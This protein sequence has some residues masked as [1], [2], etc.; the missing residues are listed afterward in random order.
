MLPLLMLI[1]R[2]IIQL[3]WID[4]HDFINTYFGIVLFPH[5]S[6]SNEH[7]LPQKQLG[8]SN[9]WLQ[10][11]SLLF[12]IMGAKRWWPKTILDWK[13]TCEKIHEF[14]TLRYGW[15][16]LRLSFSL[17]QLEKSFAQSARGHG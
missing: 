1:Y 16:T 2:C 15:N 12:S 9:Y 10:E 7:I 8:S 17:L 6:A 11:K 14:T 5:L 13:I 3:I 4:T